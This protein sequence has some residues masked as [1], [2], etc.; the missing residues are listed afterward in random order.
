MAVNGSSQPATTQP[1]LDFPSIPV[2]DSLM[3][4]MP[5]AP[6]TRDLLTFSNSYKQIIHRCADSAI[7]HRHLSR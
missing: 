6:L 4:L 2:H 1:T 7:D 3:D 5:A